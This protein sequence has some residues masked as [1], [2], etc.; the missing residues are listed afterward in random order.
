MYR[1]ADQ[2]E[3]LEYLRV[4]QIDVEKLFMGETLKRKNSAVIAHD[5]ML[6]WQKR[7]SG[8]HFMGAFSGN[9]LVDNVVMTNLVNCLWTTAQQLQLAE[10]LETEIADYVDVLNL[11]NI[12]EDLVADMIATTISDFVI[13][14]G[15][16]YLSEAQ[17]QSARSI[18]HDFLL[19]CFDWID[20]ERKE[21]FD[22]EEMTEVF[23]DILSS[24]NRYTPSYIANYNSWLEFMFVAF[25]AHIQAPD[26][27]RE[28]NEK[29]KE[30]LDVTI[31]S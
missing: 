20:K 28:A 15:Y 17:Q 24:A 2:K 12:N 1:F 4:R 14:W 5:M 18:A 8:M 26:F 11:S 30:L 13:D 29:L 19:P 21:Y 6:L 10:R 7:I 23:N 31:Q 27:D 3:A 9:G 22:E 16:R 25:I